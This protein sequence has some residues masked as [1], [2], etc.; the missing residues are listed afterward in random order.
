MDLGI[1]AAIAL[2][3]VW[4]IG[5]LIFDAPGWIHALLTVGLVLLIARI[6]ARGTAGSGPP[7]PKE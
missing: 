3:V 5:A 1:L 4:A 7:A 6:V 2:L